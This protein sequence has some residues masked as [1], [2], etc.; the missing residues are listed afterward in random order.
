MKLP[1]QLPVLAFLIFS[2]CAT[3]RTE[4][5]ETQAITT[6]NATSLFTHLSS[7]MA[8]ENENIDIIIPKTLTTLPPMSGIPTQETPESDTVK[9]RRRSTKIVLA[10]DTTAANQVAV[11]H[12]YQYKR[13]FETVT[14]QPE[15]VTK[16]S[17]MTLWF[18]TIIFIVAILLIFLP[19]KRSGQLL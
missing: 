8:D 14:H 3:H 6:T 10:Q 4:T 18:L 12:S 15:Q 9:I 11:N 13:A 1:H 19:R 17:G 7:I 2:A 16:F 5:S